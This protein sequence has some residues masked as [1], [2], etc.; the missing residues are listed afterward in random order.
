MGRELRRVP[1]DFKWPFHNVW[2]GYVNPHRVKCRDCSNGFTVAGEYLEGIVS[3]LMIAGDDSR[4]RRRH[5]YFNGLYVPNEPPS[6]DMAELSEGLAGRSAITP[7]GHDACDRGS[8]VRKIKKA[9][10]VG[11]DWGICKTCKGTA[12]HPDHQKAYEKWK[13]KDPP[14]GDGFQLWETTSEGSPVSPVFKTLDELCEWAESNASTFADSK[15]TKENWK[16]MLDEGF[17][18]HQEGNNV[19]I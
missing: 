15:T 6:A 13:P 18:C 4:K 14:K 11:K 3:L 19:F 16:K 10:G 5:P 8:S 12:R 17:V 7:F 1:L 2:K 9:A